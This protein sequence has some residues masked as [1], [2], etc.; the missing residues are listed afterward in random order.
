[1]PKLIPHNWSVPAKFRERL[2]ENAGRQRAMLHDGH[3]LLVLHEVPKP[4]DPVRKAAIFW[5]APDGAWKASSGRGG[6][7]ALRDLVESFAKVTLEMESRL[8]EARRAADYFEVLQQSGPLLRTSRNLHKALQEARDGVPAD[9]DLINVRDTMSDVERTAELVQFDAKNGLDY[10]IARRAEEQ[11]INS[12]HILATNHRLNLLA[13]LFFPAT[14]L[15]SILGMNLL[16]GFE[17]QNAPFLFWGM[18]ALAIVIGLLF[19]ASIAARA[20]RHLPT[21]ST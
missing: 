15:G 14:A 1:M 20:P 19:R 16:T 12:D 17:T 7:S 13:A 9:R 10:T 11:A 8:D 4:S 3:L 5:R 6:L 18:T 21:K 2:G